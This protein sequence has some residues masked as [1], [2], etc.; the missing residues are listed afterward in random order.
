MKRNDYYLK[1]NFVPLAPIR[2]YLRCFKRLILYF[3]RSPPSSTGSSS[4]RE[5]YIFVLPP[6]MTNLSRYPTSCSSNRVLATISKTYTHASE[7]QTLLFPRRRGMRIGEP[8]RED[9]SEDT[10]DV[11][12]MNWRKERHDLLKK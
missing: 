8:Q 5:P 11:H 1:K 7:Q 10:K 9:E 6:T 4:L 3:R 2:F 12:G